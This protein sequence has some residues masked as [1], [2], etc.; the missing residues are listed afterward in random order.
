MKILIVSLLVILIVRN[1]DIPSIPFNQTWIFEALEI[2]RGTVYSLY[3]TFKLINAELCIKNMDQ[4]E[5]PLI[6]II[7]LIINQTSDPMKYFKDVST[8]LMFFTLNKCGELNKIGPALKAQFKFIKDNPTK[9]WL[10]VLS[11][12]VNEGL[13]IFPDIAKLKQEYIDKQ[14]FQFGA[15]LSGILFNIFI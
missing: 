1:A 12:L 10:A 4:L 14:Y 9:Y 11:N 7:E 2:T 13:R 8:I 6:D 15:D 5:L 3:D